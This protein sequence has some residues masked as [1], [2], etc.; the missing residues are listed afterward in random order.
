MT[1][2]T[3]KDAYAMRTDYWRKEKIEPYDSYHCPEIDPADVQK[4]RAMMANQ[5][6]EERAPALDPLYVLQCVREAIAT[7][8]NGIFASVTY[9]AYEPIVRKLDETLDWMEAGL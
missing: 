3:T 5:F 9:L 2:T 4:I 7:E 6:D 1:E 8:A